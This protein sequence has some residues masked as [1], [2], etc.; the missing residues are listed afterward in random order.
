MPFWL[1]I[2]LTL[3]G[4]FAGAVPHIQEGAKR[5]PDS[6]FAYIFLAVLHAGLGQDAEA[7]AAASQVMRLE[8]DFGIEKWASTFLRFKNPVHEETM[9]SLLRKAGLPD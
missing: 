2:A 8:P 1:G 7:N 4:D 5:V 6:P 3:Q 9:I